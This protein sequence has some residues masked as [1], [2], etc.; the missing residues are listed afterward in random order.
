MELLFF[1]QGSIKMCINITPEQTNAET[2]GGGVD[3]CYW[4]LGT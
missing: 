2:N 1:P 4:R 3:S